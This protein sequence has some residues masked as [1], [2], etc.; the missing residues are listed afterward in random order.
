M[1][2]FMQQAV[3]ASTQKKQG[4]FNTNL[5][6]SCRLASTFSIVLQRLLS[7]HVSGSPSALVSLLLLTRRSTG[8]LSSESGAAVSDRGRRDAHLTPSSVASVTILFRPAER[9]ALSACRRRLLIALAR[10]LLATGVRSRRKSIPRRP[11]PEIA[12]GG[13]QLE[14]ERKRKQLKRSSGNSRKAFTLGKRQ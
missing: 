12:V 2:T 14:R 7:G 11:P 3:Q 4:S 1:P 6:L 9:L 13:Q 8:G 5:A 10:V